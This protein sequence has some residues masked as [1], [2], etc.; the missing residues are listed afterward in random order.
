[1]GLVEEEKRKRLFVKLKFTFDEGRQ[2][3]KGSG[4]KKWETLPKTAEV[5]ANKLHKLYHQT[6]ERC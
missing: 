2:A 4:V 3:A 1:M 6:S 5:V